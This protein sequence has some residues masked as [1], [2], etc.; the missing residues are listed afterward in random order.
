[1]LSMKAG[2]RTVYSWLE[3]IIIII[4]TVY[5]V[6]VVVVIVIIVVVCVSQFIQKHRV[7]NNVKMIFAPIDWTVT[8]K[9]K[10]K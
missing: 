10:Y 2:A 4:I 3:I 9:E 6:V 1:M 7:R 5:V 8:E